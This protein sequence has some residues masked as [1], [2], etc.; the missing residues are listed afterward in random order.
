MESWKVPQWYKRQQKISTGDKGE[1]R[2]REI[3]L[4]DERFT[5]PVGSILY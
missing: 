2:Q 5:N 3:T 4:Q 1:I